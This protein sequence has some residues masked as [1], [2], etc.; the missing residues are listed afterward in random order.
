MLISP[1]RGQACPAGIG[2]SYVFGLKPGDKVTAIGPFGDFHVKQ[3]QREMVYLGGGAG[4]APLRSHIAHLLETQQT[5]RRVSFWY[6]ARSLQELFYQEYFDQLACQHDNFSFHVALS[7]AQPEDRWTSY[8]GF[9]HEVLQQEYLA[10]HPDPTAIDYYLCGP[11]VMIQ[12]ATKMLKELG[13]PPTQIAYD[14]F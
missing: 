3:N 10:T 14:E 4:M 1:P 9:I 13:V 11:P 5:S 6:G 12:T 2:S 8:T 7:E